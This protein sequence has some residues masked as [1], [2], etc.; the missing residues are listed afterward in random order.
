MKNATTTLTAQL[1]NLVIILLC[2][3][4]L[5]AINTLFNDYVIRVASTVFVFMILAVSYNLINGVTGQLSLEPNGFVAIGAYVT[6]ILILGSDSK[7]DMYEMA[8]PSPL[9]LAVH[10]SF[11]PALLLSGICAAL[12]AV[13]L[14][15]PVFRV[16]GDYLAIVTLGFGFI[17]KILAINNPQITNGAI[18]L[19]DIPQQPHLLF[20][21]GITALLATGLILQLVW[22]KY[23]RMMKAIRDD[24]DAAIAMGVNTFRI[25]TCAFATSAFFEGIGGGLMAS[26]LTT[27]SPG[28]FDFMLTFQLL[29]IIVLG[30]LGSTTGALLGT[31]LVVG[32][33]EWLRFLDQPLTLFGH[34]LGAFPGL[35]MVVFSLVLLVVMLFAREGLLGKK[36]IW[37]LTRS[38][39]HHNGK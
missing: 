34:D 37:Q 7:L 14:A 9:V 23:G 15:F 3:G 1:R 28:L 27:I 22:S 16:R 35:R 8:Q 20:W 26:L 21:C 13:C 36:E 11:L 32:S 10:A 24:E 39:G 6:G 25:K 33:A 18:G 12:V 38:G 31:I 17:I 19:N 29:I 30:G 4:L 2:L 5:L